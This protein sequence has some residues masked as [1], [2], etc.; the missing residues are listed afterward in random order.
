MPITAILTPAGDYA[1][2]ASVRNWAG[3]RT[4]IV[5]VLKCTH[6]IT[7]ITLNDAQT[8]CTIASLLGFEPGSL[9]WLKHQHNTSVDI[10]IF[11]RAWTQHGYHHH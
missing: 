1:S 11:N 6:Y 5:M 9:V 8:G 2:T 10:A 3:Y 4:F 7:R